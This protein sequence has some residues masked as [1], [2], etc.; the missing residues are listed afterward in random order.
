MQHVILICAW[1]ACDVQD[2]P[3]INQMLYVQLLCDLPGVLI[4][5]LNI[6]SRVGR[7]S[8]VFV[9]FLNI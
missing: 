9:V 7:C 2:F 1:E 8:F 6:M 5:K 4:R 3:D